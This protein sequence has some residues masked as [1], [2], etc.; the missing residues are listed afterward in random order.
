MRKSQQQNREI[1]QRNQVQPWI[2]CI[3]NHNNVCENSPIPFNY[4]WQDTPVKTCRKSKNLNIISYQLRLSIVE[5]HKCFG[6]RLK[7]SS[8][9][10]VT[11]N[12]H[13]TLPSGHGWTNTELLCPDKHV[14]RL[15]NCECGVRS[16][17]CAYG[18]LK[19]CLYPSF[20]V[21]CPSLP[22]LSII[23]TFCL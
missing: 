10:D 17:A 19:S 6:Q 11:Y 7:K 3:W 16:V 8:N 15:W 23:L 1:P 2:F 13:K 22:L 18:R 14:V 4:W 12:G 21:W 9:C 5:G 20:F